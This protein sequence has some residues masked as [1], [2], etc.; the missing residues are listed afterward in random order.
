MVMPKIGVNMTEAV[1]AKWLIKPGDKVAKDAHILDAETDKATQEILA[2]EEGVVL[3][4][5]AAEGDT[6]ECQQPILTLAAEGEDLDEAAAFEPPAQAAVSGAPEPVAV[7]LAAPVEVPA[8]PEGVRVRISPLAKKTARELGVDYMLV[9]PARP[10][11]RIVRADVFK[12][13]DNKKASVPAPAPARVPIPA[14]APVTPTAGERLPLP[15]IRRVIAVKMTESVTTKPSVS[16]TLTADAGALLG[17][18]EQ[19]KKLGAEVKL[20]EM[21]IKI[22][23]HALREHPMLMARIEGAELV[24]PAEINIGAAVDTERG[25]IVPVIKNAD[26]KGAGQIGAEL[27]AF[28]ESG[29]AG[30]LT[31]DDMSGGVFTITNLGMFEIEQFDAII[32]PPECAI[33][34]VGAIVRAPAVCGDE[35]VISSRMQL[36]LSFDHRVVD[37]APAARFLQ[38]VK[39]L[40]EAPLGLLG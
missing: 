18:R 4:L 17:W 3:R 31:P 24:I 8:V 33:L 14:A 37:G 27:R 35:I 36:T 19:S 15:G 10:G 7:V 29:R 22:A 20:N 32:N 13:T 5:L 30:M 28:A 40:V 6:V 39:H 12:Y 11:G 38:R 34:A 21:L 1:I 2:T 23:A 16:L 9:P 25:L 26:R